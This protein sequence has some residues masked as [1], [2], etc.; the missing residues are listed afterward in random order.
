MNFKTVLIVV[1]ILSTVQSLSAQEGLVNS[2][3]IKENDLTLKRLAQPYTYF[4]KAGRKFGILGYE[5]GSFEAWAYPLKLF[6]NFEFSFFIGSSTE[7]IFGK[8]IVKRIIVSPASTT[9]VYTFQSFTVKAT[10]ITPIN[11]PGAFILLEVNSTEPLTVVCSFLPVLQPMWPGGIGGQYAFWDDAVK[12]YTISESSRKNHGFIGSPAASG[13][14]YTPAHM[15]SDNPNQF[16]IIIEDPESVR[17]KYIPIIMAGG[18][19]DREDIKNIYK[20]IAGNIVGL[21][22]DTYDYYENLRLS[23]LR[24]D[25]PEKTL[26]TAFEWAKVAYDNLIIDNPD[27]GKGMVAGLGASGKGGRPG[28]GWY[29]GGDSFINSFS[30]NSYGAYSTVRDALLFNLKWQR[31]DGKI[32]HE[33]SQ[34]AG[35]IDWFGDYPYAYIHG[36]T[37]P[38]FVIAVYDHYRMTGDREFL[39][40]CWDGVKRAF[41]WS[42]ATDGDGDGLMDNEKAGLG[43]LEFGS[44][45]DI[46]TDIYIGAVW[47]KAI[48]SMN[49]LAEALNDDAYRSK[50]DELYRIA[51]NSFNNK[52]WDNGLRQY[53]YAFSKDGRLV[54]E[55]TPWPAIGM[56]LDLG[57]PERNEDTI[58]RMNSHELTT[59]WGIRMISVKSERFEPLNYNYGA[60]WPFLTS[61][62]ATAQFKNNYHL[63]GYQSLMSAV[64]HVY[65]NAL[66]YVNE[67]FS[68]HQHIWPQE[69]VAHQGFCTAATVLPLVRGLLGLD[70]DANRKQLVFEPAFPADWNNVR[71]GNYKLG[72]GSFDFLYTR[73]DNRI[74]VNITGRN[75]NGYHLSFKPSFG[76][77]TGIRSVK[78]NGRDKEFETEKFTQVVRPVIEHTLTSDNNIVIEIEP[79]VEILPVVNKSDVGEPNKGLKIIKSFMAGN[80]LKIICEGLAGREYIIKVTNPENIRDVSGAR[81]V[82]E[83]LAVGFPGGDTVE[84]MRKEITVRVK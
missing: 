63:Q 77:G 9:I 38:Y 21:Y 13:I 48:Y 76:A 16:N 34:A 71:I 60:V 75:I 74:E 72:D 79:A 25:T 43:A 4:D 51:L 70:G 50:T 11:E 6:R 61:F 27:L 45:T 44:L 66:G 42:L 80:D 2:F 53:S 47:V 58:V 22:R 15:L 19:G 78:I 37:S 56:F 14:S 36:D 39:S 30:M 12:A 5:S 83:G 23:T 20:N 28:F 40:E 33:I 17:G 35:Y 31:E 62:V 67:V 3:E 32:A 59:D 41:E 64:Q 55:L 46:K 7:P 49:Y 65:N 52:F 10:Y 8:D 73:N 26:D 81:L 18:K 29:F 84:F 82:N 24:I 69:S 57:L 68:G 1:M 54:R